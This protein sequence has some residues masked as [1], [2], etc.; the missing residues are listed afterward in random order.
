M[1]AAEQG[2]QDGWI[3]PRSPDLP[4]GAVLSPQFIVER[5]GSADRV[6]DDHA[7]SGLNDTIDDAPTIYDRVV[8]LVLLLRYLGLL[9]SSLPTGVLFKLDVAAA[10]KLLLMHPAWQLKQGIAVPY[11]E[12]GK[13]VVQY[14]LQWRA[15]FGSKSSPYLWTSVMAAVHWIITRAAPSVPTPLSYMDDS[16]GID[17]S[18][19]LVPFKHDGETKRIPPA[20][21]EILR[22][23]DFLGLRWK[24]KKTE[25]GRRLLI[26][27]LE[28]DLDSATVSLPSA[29]V[30]RFAD[31]VVDFLREPARKHPLRRWRQLV[32][33]ANWALTV[34]PYDR[35]LLTPL[36]DK[37][38]LPSG[39]KREH[40]AYSA[41][42]INNAVRDALHQFASNLVFSASLDLRD[43]GL[44]RWSRGEADVV[45]HCDACL[46]AD[47]RSGSGFGFWYEM[48]GRRFHYFSRPRRHL[49][50]IP[51][52]ETLTVALAIRHSFNLSPRPKRVL[53][54]TDSS[55]AVYAYD[56]GAAKNTVFSPMQ[57]LLV[58][59]F[60]E[61]R[62]AK[63]D[64]RLH[65]VA[66]K[67]NRTADLPSRARI[68]DLRR[69]FGNS[70][71]SFLAP[72]ELL[73][74]ATN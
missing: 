31:E 21:A 63:V 55:P 45:F 49:Q 70:L 23:W 33:W 72:S 42:F 43:P 68:Y 15:A 6:V 3:S 62:A 11:E 26:T 52:A 53:V 66:G 13:T 67:A 56:S 40:S 12:E 59:S 50:R 39:A 35:P 73:E 22:V 61:M 71:Y 44:S 1:A 30:Q 25:H 65:H 32:G 58:A 14:H 47:D 7:A 60:G 54:R 20:Q 24:W 8:D 27:G 57:K 64:V 17:L 16:Y 51:Y 37:L 29:A 4:E 34:R 19:R 2:E 28:V 41:V 9:S 69:L 36:F 74:G 48:N 18:G 38:A 46:E 10:F 5:E